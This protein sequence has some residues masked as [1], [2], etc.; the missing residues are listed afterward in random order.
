MLGCSILPLG[1]ALTRQ[2]V[3]DLPPRA[4]AIT[5]DDGAAD[6]ST[7]AYPVLQALEVPAMLYQTT[8]YVDKP[9]PV[10]N[11]MASYL[12]WHARGR[13]VRLPW[14]SSAVRI[15]PSTRHREFDEL[16]GSLL[17]HVAGEKLDGQQQT[18]LL[19]EIAAAVGVGFDDFLAQRL[20]FLMSTSELRELDEEL[21]DVQLHTHRHRTPRDKQQFI[22]E[23]A[24]NAAHLNRILGR[25]L[26]LRH[27]CYPSGVY[28][29]EFGAWLSEWGVVSSTTCDPGILSPADDRFYI[30]RLM[31]TMHVDDAIFDAWVTG[32]AAFIP[33]RRRA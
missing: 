25:T 30:P 6:F 31:D 1:E 8:W 12:M 7:R 24:D 33:G 26:D 5:F 28:F 4:V 11:T 27:F 18:A 19:N 23:L 21:V 20:L 10:F 14:R 2:A 22:R 16:H 15:A 29:P 32:A 9:Y 17:S 3:G 13:D